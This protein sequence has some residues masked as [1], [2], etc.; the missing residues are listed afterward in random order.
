MLNIN[1]LPE[2]YTPAVDAVQRQGLGLNVFNTNTKEHFH[3][4][5]DSERH[6]TLT[7]IQHELD[8]EYPESALVLPNTAPTGWRF[9]PGGAAITLS[10][11]SHRID[12]KSDE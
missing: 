12:R 4:D 6:S 7:I 1:S 9:P 3:V 11:E 2:R 8:I 5:P 10:S